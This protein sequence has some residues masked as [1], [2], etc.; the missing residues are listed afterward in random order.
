M[1]LR[2]KALLCV[3]PVADAI[4]INICLMRF[5]QTSNFRLDDLLMDIQYDMEISRY[6]LAF[7]VLVEYIR[8]SHSN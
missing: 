3:Q 2:P 1:C 6:F 8:S 4:K 5:I 7:Q